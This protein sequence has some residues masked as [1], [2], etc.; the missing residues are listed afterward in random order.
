[1]LRTSSRYSKLKKSKELATHSGGVG[2]ISS[3]SYMYTINYADM[4]LYAFI[5]GF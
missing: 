2:N 3:A 4:K 5:D 1:M